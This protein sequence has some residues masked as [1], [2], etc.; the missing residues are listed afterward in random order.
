[1]PYV[2]GGVVPRVDAFI[3]FVFVFFIVT[4]VNFGCV[5]SGC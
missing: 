2:L 4:G 3:H 5:F 1:M